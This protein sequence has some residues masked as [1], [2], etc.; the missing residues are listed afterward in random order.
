MS[1]FSEY[2]YLFLVGKCHITFI[3][4]CYHQ[5]YPVERK[6]D[7]KLF[8]DYGIFIFDFDYTLVDSSKGIIH[9]YNTAFKELG[10]KEQ[11]DETIKKTI[12][13]TV[14]ESFRLMTSCKDP[15]TEQEYYKTFLKAAD[16]YMNDNTVFFD[17]ADTMLRNL[18]AKDCIV[19]IVSSK[20]SYRIDDFLLKSNCRELIDIIIGVNDVTSSKPDPEGLIKVRELSKNS[21]VKKCVYCGD[22]EVDAIAAERADMD[23]IAVLS[24]T[25]PRTVFE[26]YPNIAIL[27][28]VTHITKNNL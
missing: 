13:L 11:D 18:K 10:F 19:A 16:S 24:G 7:F 26:R 27:P 17:G 3:K 8:N 5:T 15:E 21:S 6:G 1:L 4:L 12:G 22:N 23:F 28:D 25:T 20:P 14:S 9:C 2:I